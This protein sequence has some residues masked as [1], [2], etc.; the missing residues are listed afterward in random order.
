MQSGSEI[1]GIISSGG[2]GGCSFK[3]HQIFQKQRT[4]RGISFSKKEHFVTCFCIKIQFYLIY[5]NILPWWHEIGYTGGLYPLPSA[6][7]HFNCV[8]FFLGII[9]EQLIFQNATGK[10][11]LLAISS[12][13]EV[14]ICKWWQPARHVQ[15]DFMM[16]SLKNYLIKNGFVGFVFFK[17]PKEHFFMMTVL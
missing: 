13:F 4:K 6:P 8:N 3:T 5:N 10:L 15:G 7:Y 2:G 16:A 14:L 11:V 12:N 1:C 9:W 17:E